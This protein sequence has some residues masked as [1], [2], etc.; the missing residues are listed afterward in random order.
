[1]ARVEADVDR[2]L[3]EGCPNVAEP[4]VKNC[5]FPERNGRTRFDTALELVGS[6]VDRGQIVKDW[7]LFNSAREMDDASGRVDIAG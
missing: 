7:S 5:R 1:M 6:R 4:V 3:W 2:M